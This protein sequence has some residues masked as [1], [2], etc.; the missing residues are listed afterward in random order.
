MTATPTRTPD[1]RM[2]ALHR[3][4]EIRTYRAELKRKIAAG[5]LDPE[6]VLTRPAPELMTMKVWDLLMAI[7]AVGRC[8]ADRALRRTR[9]SPS[10]T[11]GGLSPR[12][13][14]EIIDEVMPRYRAARYRTAA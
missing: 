11:I 13:R 5:D 6:T 8:K 2:A 1:Q 12:Q 14:D 4:N 7:P 9:T 10:K 3:A